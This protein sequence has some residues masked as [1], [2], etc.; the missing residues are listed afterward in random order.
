[1]KKEVGEAGQFSNG[2]KLHLCLGSKLDNLKNIHSSYHQ[3]K[4]RTV[5]EPNYSYRAWVWIDEKL[6]YVCL[7]INKKKT[8]LFW[9]LVL[10]L[11]NKQAKSKQKK[12][13]WTG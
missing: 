9:L 8:N 10:G 4:H 2:V 6:I 12:S 1:M 13:S 3:P 5:N 7:F 11:F